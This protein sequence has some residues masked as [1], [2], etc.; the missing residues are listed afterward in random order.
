MTY[1]MIIKADGAPEMLVGFP[2]KADRAEQFMRFGYEY[3]GGVF[4]P[5][6]YREARHQFGFRSKRDLQLTCELCAGQEYPAMVHKR[7]MFNM[8]FGGQ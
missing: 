6:D 8:I 1:A 4:A 5:M 2:S 3:P 7:D